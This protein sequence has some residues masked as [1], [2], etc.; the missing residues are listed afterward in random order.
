MIIDHTYFIGKL[1]LPQTGNTE[2]VALV[3]DFI[4]RYEPEYLERVL[5]LNLY[6]AFIAGLQEDPIPDRWLDLL[7]GVDFTYKNHLHHWNGFAPLSEGSILNVD[8]ANKIE[9]IVDGPGEFDPVDGSD[10]LTLP[11]SFVGVP[12]T[13]EL[14]GTGDLRGTTSPEYTVAGNLLTLISQTWNSGATIFLKK[15]TSIFIENTTTIKRSPIANYVYYKFLE[16]DAQTTTL[17]GQASTYTENATRVN[18]VPKMIDA[19]NDMIK[20]NRELN[21]FLMTNKTVYPEWQQPPS[22]GWWGNWAFNGWPGNNEINGF[23]NS[24]D[25]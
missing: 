16:D 17:V 24:F 1:N 8:E 10:E 12:F 6:K 20:M 23:K 22:W 11:P 9:L 25:L 5:G 2:G 4:K 7:T 21:R 13:I 14:R 3:E 19:W 18:P 15:G